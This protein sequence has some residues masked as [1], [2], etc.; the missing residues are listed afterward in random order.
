MTLLI[1][2]S[3]QFVLHAGV[4]FWLCS[5]NPFPRWALVY[6]KTARVFSTQAQNTLHALH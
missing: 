2:S 1:Q 5:Y 6:K 4:L 3:V